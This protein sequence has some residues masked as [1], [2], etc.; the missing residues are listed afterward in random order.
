M[1]YYLATFILRNFVV[2]V[3]NSQLD[4]LCPRPS[5]YRCIIDTPQH[6]LVELNK[7]NRPRKA[8]FYGIYSELRIAPLLTHPAMMMQ[9]S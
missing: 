7:C 5:I 4:C 1:V 9:A 6:I 8:D 2:V 3:E